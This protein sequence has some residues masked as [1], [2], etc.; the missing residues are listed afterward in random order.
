MASTVQELKQFVSEFAGR[1]AHSGHSER[2]LALCIEDAPEAVAKYMDDMR[3]LEHFLSEANDTIRQMSEE[4]AAVSGRRASSVRVNPETY[5]WLVGCLYMCEG[6]VGETGKATTPEEYE[7]TRGV[8]ELVSRLGD[9]SIPSEFGV[10]LYEES[11]A[12]SISDGEGL[13]GKEILVIPDRNV[14]RGE[15]RILSHRQE[16]EPKDEDDAARALRAFL[17]SVLDALPEDKVR[18]SW[19]KAAESDDYEYILA[20]L[21]AVA[22]DVAPGTRYFRDLA[23]H[24]A[25]A[26]K[27]PEDQRDPK[28]VYAPTQFG[29]NLDD[30]TFSGHKWS[31]LEPSEERAKKYGEYS[32]TR[33]PGAVG[34]KW[35]KWAAVPPDERDLRISLRNLAI[36]VDRMDAAVVAERM[37]AAG[38]PEETI[39]NIVR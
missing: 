37:R 13:H 7:A 29:D 12:V 22:D 38:I 26:E 21:A 17:R 3:K 25:V 15:V 10:T 27:R 8:R 14:P 39:R 31:A 6:K 2:S 20:T 18:K 30:A 33:R 5:E 34:P 4:D 16:S 32:N 23:V 36:L 35:T 24:P 1:F 9:N 11:G 19:R 28:R